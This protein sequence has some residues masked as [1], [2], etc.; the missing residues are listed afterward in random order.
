MA[1]MIGA[2]VIVGYTVLGGFLAVSTTDLIQAIVMS[3]ALVIIIFFGISQA[4]GMGTVMDNAKTLPGYLSL[5]QGYD[6]ASGTAGVFG[7][8]PIVS[9]LAWGLGYFGM[10]HILL[11][12]MA[13]RNPEEIKIS[14]RIASVWVVLS[15]GIAVL[16]GII[17]YSVSATG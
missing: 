16:I 10:P 7:F 12:F 13:I 2:A 1:M 5:T 3:I 9:T 4:G 6:A 15:M 11:R 17:G 8:L 14:R